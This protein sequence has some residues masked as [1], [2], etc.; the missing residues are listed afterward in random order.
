MITENTPT[1]MQGNGT[2]DAD[3]QHMIT[4]RRSSSAASSAIN[5]GATSS[6]LLSVNMHRGISER[7]GSGTPSVR[8]WT[9]TPDAVTKDK[10][11]ETQCQ[12]M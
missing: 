12:S 2:D 9:P 6:A 7:R 4:T 10:T 1:S 3:P 8:A 11:T 5:D